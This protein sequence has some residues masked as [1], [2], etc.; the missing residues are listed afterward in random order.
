VDILEADELFEGIEM[1]FDGY[2]NCTFSYVGVS[3][4]YL[5]EAEYKVPYS[6][7][8]EVEYLGTDRLCIDDCTTFR[9]SIQN[10]TIF[11]KVS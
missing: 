3:G 6:E 1:V 2:H 11:E 9:V 5:L 8:H 7:I 4:D 10:D